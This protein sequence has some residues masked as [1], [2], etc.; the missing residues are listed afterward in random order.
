MKR[1]TTK[2]IEFEAGR[3]FGASWKNRDKSV[4]TLKEQLQAAIDNAANLPKN[5][6]EMAK[7]ILE[8]AGDED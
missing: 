7:Y 2:Q 6:L 8:C 3:I 1:M 5:K 4:G